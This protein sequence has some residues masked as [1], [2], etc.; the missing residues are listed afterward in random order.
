MYLTIFIGVWVSC[1][2]Y[3]SYNVYQERF[4]QRII[5]LG[6]SIYY[7]SE[8]ILSLMENVIA[9]FTGRFP[10]RHTSSIVKSINDKYSMVKVLE[11]DFPSRSYVEKIVV[12]EKTPG[13]T[14]QSLVLNP[15]NS[16][17]PIN[18]LRKV[19]RETGIPASYITIT[20]PL[21][22]RFPMTE[23]DIDCYPKV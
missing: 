6:D 15:K 11:W 12:Y 4:K 20:S 14:G 17:N 9:S 18:S 1:L 10:D 13:L 16:L 22:T 7:Q 8:A 23:R 5:S 19:S 2:S 21:G 3:L